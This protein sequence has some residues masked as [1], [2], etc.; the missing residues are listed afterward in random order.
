MTA[1]E[2]DSLQ[3][4]VERVD[5]TQAYAVQRYDPS[6]T[7][8]NQFIMGQATEGI[9]GVELFSRFRMQKN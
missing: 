2:V 9:Q 6:V 8:V 4:V 1:E 7:Q 3:V 5:V